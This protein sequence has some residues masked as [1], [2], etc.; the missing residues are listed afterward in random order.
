MRQYYAAFVY[1]SRNVEIDHL[2]V[3]CDIRQI[4]NISFLVNII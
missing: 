4:W 2:P 1:R 3:R